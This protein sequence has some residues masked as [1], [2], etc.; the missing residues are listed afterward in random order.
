M[1]VAAGQPIQ[2]SD[3]DYTTLFTKDPMTFFEAVLINILWD[4]TP[5]S[6]NHELIA[7]Q[8]L[9]FEKWFKYHEANLYFDL[10]SAAD[11]IRSEAYAAGHLAGRIHALTNIPIKRGALGKFVDISAVTEELR[12]LKAGEPTGVTNEPIQP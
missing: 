8:K 2:L 9:I 7:R 10:E 11:T 1:K 4:K 12:K 3:G 5:A 6:I